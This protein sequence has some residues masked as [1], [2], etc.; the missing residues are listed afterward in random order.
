ML[1]GHYAAGCVLKSVERKISLGALFIAVQLIDIIWAVF[2][3]FGIE[4]ME[5][6]RA[7]IGLNALKGTSLAYSHTLVLSLILA[8]LT[9]VIISLLPENRFG[10]YGKKVGAVMSIAVLSHFI[11]DLIVHNNDLPVFGADSYKLG[12]GLWNLPVLNYSIEAVLVL[13]GVWIYLRKTK[14]EGFTGKY[15][16]AIFGVLMI[17]YNFSSLGTP[18]LPNTTMLAISSLVTYITFPI[19]GFWL[20][21]KRKLI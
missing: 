20:D 15:G 10:L 16:M 9:F 12:F 19:I 2:L 11:L 8:L 4:R 5:I 3:L 21:K 6:D 18:T 13:I 14:G 7:S 17:L 1:V